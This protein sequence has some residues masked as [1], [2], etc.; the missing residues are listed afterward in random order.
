M[1]LL[2]FDLSHTPV[3]SP[4]LHLRAP[5]SVDCFLI[6]QICGVFGLLVLFRL[7]LNS[8]G[9]LMIFFFSISNRR[10]RDV[11]KSKHNSEAAPQHLSGIQVNLHALAQG[12]AEAQ[13]K[14]RIRIW[15]KC[16]FGRTEFFRCALL[17]EVCLIITCP[18]AAG[19]QV[20]PCVQHDQCSTESGP[21]QE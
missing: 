13:A 21:W 5:W 16:A 12:Y 3:Y 14:K 7:L 8:T 18:H 1:G 15:Q 4:G 11:E 9:L 20:D 6:S 17:S 2:G 19:T 10:N